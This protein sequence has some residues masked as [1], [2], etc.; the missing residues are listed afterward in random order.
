MILLDSIKERS[1]FVGL[2]QLKD[3]IWQVL[4][5]YP[6][7][8]PFGHDLSTYSVCVH[9]AHE[10]FNDYNKALALFLSIQDEFGE[11]LSYLN[12]IDL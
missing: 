10:K 4:G 7:V 8:F 2:Y 6:V 3:N 9:F 12:S 1:F 11:Y 5:H